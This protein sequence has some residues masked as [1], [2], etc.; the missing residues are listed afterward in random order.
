ME[1]ET[2]EERIEHLLREHPELRD[3]DLKLVF[4]YWEVF[5]G[6]RIV[7]IENGLTSIVL[8]T[9]QVSNFETIR[10]CRQ[11]IQSPQGKNALKPSAE[12]QEKREE[13]QK[14]VVN[15]ALNGGSQYV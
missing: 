7:E 1:L 3:D 2:T 13:H 14:R 12:S 9:E 4:K 11:K 6:A 10:R 5:D 15:Y 8:D